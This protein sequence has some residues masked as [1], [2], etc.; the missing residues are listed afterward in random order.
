MKG[1]ARCK[2][3]LFSLD[4]F[5][6][7]LSAPVRGCSGAFHLEMMLDS[8]DSCDITTSAD[9]FAT[10]LYVGNCHSHTSKTPVRK[11]YNFSLIRH[12]HTH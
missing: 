8:Y 12:T 4:I 2:S 1:N 9:A 6:C 10:H 3:K 11:T 5:T 7:L